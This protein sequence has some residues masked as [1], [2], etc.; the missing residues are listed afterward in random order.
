MAGTTKYFLDTEF[1]HREEN[2]LDLISL[3]L[4][5][6]DGREYYAVN[7]WILSIW[8][9]IYSIDP[10]VADNVFPHLEHYSDHPEVYACTGEIAQHLVD[11]TVDTNPEFWA[12][13][14]SF[15]WVLLT[16]LYGKMVNMPE[17]WPW[18]FYDLKVWADWVGVKDL[19]Q[20]GEDEHHA[21]YDAR[22][23]KQTYDYL[24]NITGGHPSE[25]MGE[26]M[27]YEV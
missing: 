16:G 25:V 15:D 27:E 19:P 20:Q 4:V 17:H 2:Q 8:P 26:A 10:W 12:Y 11:F 9:E 22:W 24:Y 5:C 23:D 6:E 18:Y 1:I 7:A 3:A 13:Y 21:L 14:G